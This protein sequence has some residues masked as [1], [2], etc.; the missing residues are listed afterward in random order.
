[1]LFPRV[2]QQNESQRSSPCPIRSS[3]L[4]ISGQD[5]FTLDGKGWCSHRGV[6]HGMMRVCLAMSCIVLASIIDFPEHRDVLCDEDL[7]SSYTGIRFA[8]G[9]I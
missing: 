2:R 7:F 5:F 3:F 8:V 1:M 6:I 4:G 9:F